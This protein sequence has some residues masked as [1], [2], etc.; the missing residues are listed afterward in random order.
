MGVARRTGSGG[1]AEA[2]LRQLAAAVPE[3][4]DAARTA[5]GRLDRARGRALGVP[6]AQRA[7]PPEGGTGT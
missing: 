1:A 7:L 5:L 4:A 3:E 6:L 2:Y